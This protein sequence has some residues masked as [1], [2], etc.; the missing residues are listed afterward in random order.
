MLLAQNVVEI[1]TVV[2]IALIS[3]IFA[4]YLMI[5][6]KN[7]WLG[8]K[9][10]FYRCANKECKKIFKKPIEL[11]DLSENPPRI[12]PACPE[13]GADLNFFFG[14]STVKTA[15]TKKKTL[16]H[17]KKPE[18]KSI[19]KKVE[20]KRAEAPNQHESKVSIPR[21]KVA[22][23]NPIA[24][25]KKVRATDYSDCKYYFGYLASREKQKEIPETCLECPRSLDCM[26]SNYKSE[27]TVGEISKWYHVTAQL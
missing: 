25:K 26:L 12:Y 19:K 21:E 1:V 6:R 17:Q 8:G 9:S 22:A 10:D 5:L 20:I 4:V 24:N 11:K 23:P 27:D 14:S 2:T 7:G 15:K 18:I 3:V 13:C 16:I